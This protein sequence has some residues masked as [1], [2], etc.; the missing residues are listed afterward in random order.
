MMLRFK[1]NIAIFVT[2]LGIVV[3]FAM[4]ELPH[5]Q[6]ALATIV[7][8]NE[9]LLQSIVDRD[10]QRLANEIFEDRRRAIALRL[11]EMRKVEGIRAISVFDRNGKLLVEAGDGPGGDLALEN[12]PLSPEKAKVSLSRSRMEASTWAW[13]KPGGRISTPTTSASA[14][15]AF[16]T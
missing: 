16:A 4:I 10:E 9:I 3:V 12:R 6:R 2:Y 11:A 1:V 7:R 8:H 13:S 14:I 5:Q 15:T